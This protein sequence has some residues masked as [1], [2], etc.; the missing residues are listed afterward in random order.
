MK[1]LIVILNVSRLAEIVR[2]RPN[3]NEEQEGAGSEQRA[4][5]STV[6]AA[7][8]DV[9]WNH[10]ATRDDALALL[11]GGSE[12]SDEPDTPRRATESVMT[13][14]RYNAR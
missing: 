3:G 9:F 11:K 1:E 13:R 8:R 7:A 5:T 14:Q 12:P 2:S 6:S 4:N 10:S